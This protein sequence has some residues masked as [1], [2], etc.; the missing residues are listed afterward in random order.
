MRNRQLYAVLAAFAEEAGA[1]LAAETADGAEVPF[2]IV[3]A[4]APKRQTPLYCYRPLTDAF[5]DDR[6]GAL[7]RLPS[8]LPAAHALARAGGLPSYL[9][10]RGRR[11]VPDE[12]DAR[13][14]ATLVAFLGRVFE[15]SA[16][17]ALLPE[18]VERAYAELE[19]IVFDGR[20]E[21]VVVAPVTGLRLASAEVPLDEA[22]SLARVDVLPDAPAELLA[23]DGDEGAAVLAVLRWEAA[24]GDEDPLS[25]AIVR[26]RRLVTALRLY[27]D[28]APRLA[29]GGWA[30]SGGGAWHAVS[31]GLGGGRARAAFRLAREQ[32]DELRAFCNLVTRRRPVSGEIAWAL[33]RFE[34]GCERASPFEALTDHLLALRAL[35]AP[36][37]G[38]ERFA[39]RVAALC[40][41]PDSRPALVERVAHALSIERSVVAGLT[42]HEPEIAA[43]ADEIARHLRAIL[44]D[45]LCGHLD[46]DVR[47]VADRIIADAAAE[48][49]TA[50]R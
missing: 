10:A 18:R 47:S 19:A 48:R 40:A 17:F 36:E 25:H 11:P 37:A 41:Q 49:A 23:G 28:A 12:Q 33:G 21:I 24:A 14:A 5:I 8:Y 26:F 6:A 20:T 42:L 44:R 39:Q 27:D 30:R 43:I 22:L 1:H 50:T 3:P 45:V 2:E 13:V 38:I 34:M 35:L 4:A 32:E 16:D 29:P 31:L 15:D 7:A 46:S 9:E